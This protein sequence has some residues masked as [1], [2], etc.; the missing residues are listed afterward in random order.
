MVPSKLSFFLG[1]QLPSQHKESKQLRLVNG[2]LQLRF[3]FL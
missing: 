2:D 3:G 1:R